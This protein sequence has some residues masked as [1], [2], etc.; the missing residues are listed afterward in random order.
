[1]TSPIVVLEITDFGN[2]W[3][4]GHGITSVGW[5]ASALANKFAFSLPGRTARPETHWK[6][7]MVLLERE[8]ARDQTFQK[9]SGRR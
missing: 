2:D 7:K 3:G 6:F 8:E 4:R 1:M 9:D 5:E